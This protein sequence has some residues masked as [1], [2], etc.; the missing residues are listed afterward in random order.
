MTLGIEPFLFAAL[1][2]LQQ[3]QIIGSVVASQ[4]ARDRQLQLAYIRELIAELTQTTDDLAH[5][6]SEFPM[7][8]LVG[9]QFT[10]LRIQA[11]KIIPL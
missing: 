7:Q 1:S 3:R 11:L 5:Q 10:L 8:S 6:A 2:A 9:V 4:N